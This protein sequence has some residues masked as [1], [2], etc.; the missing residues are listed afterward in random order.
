MLTPAA[1][2]AVLPVLSGGDT[3]TLVPL[4]AIGVFVDLTL[5]QAGM[6]VHWCRERGAR[7]RARTAL[8]GTGALLAGVSAVVV[9]ATRFQDGARLVV[10]ALP[11]L[12]LAFEAVRRAYARIGERLGV[13]RLPGRS[14]SGMRQRR[15]GG[16][17]EAINGGRKRSRRGFPRLV[18][19]LPEPLR[20]CDGRRGLRRHHD[21]GVRAG[22]PRRQGGDEAVTAENIVGLVVAVALLGYL[23]LALIYPE[24]F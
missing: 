18:S 14:P 16:R 4:F 10:I 17:M 21:R 7:W 9:T 12:V 23:V 24:R 20:S 6:V 13:G 11:L 19:S 15:S 5:A 2:S 3:N 1:V 8:N 22:G